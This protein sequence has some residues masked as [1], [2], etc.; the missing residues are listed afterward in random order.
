MLTSHGLESSYTFQAQN[1]VYF[2]IKEMLEGAT[3]FCCKLTKD[4]PFEKAA[5]VILRL[6]T[7]YHSSLKYSYKEE[8]LFF[9][10]CLILAL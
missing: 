2:S 5:C 10:N 3:S 8:N 1:N 6:S 4:L 9:R 7:D